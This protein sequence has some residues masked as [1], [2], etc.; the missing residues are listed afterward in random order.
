MQCCNVA[1]SVLVFSKYW[2]RRFPPLQLYPYSEGA[3]VLIGTK[4][5]YGLV[6]SLA[7]IA[8]IDGDDEQDDTDSF[9]RDR[10]EL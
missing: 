9:G 10:W 2:T 3:G 5:E 4:K 8:W 6:A 7:D 1:V